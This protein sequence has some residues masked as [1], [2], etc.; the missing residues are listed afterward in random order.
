MPPTARR[1]GIPP[2]ERGVD[3]RPDEA[4]ASFHEP[5]ETRERQHTSDEHDGP[6]HR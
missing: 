6:V 2:V 5:P 4:L 3:V 1:L